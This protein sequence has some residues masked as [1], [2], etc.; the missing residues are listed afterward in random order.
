[1]GSAAVGGTGEMVPVGVVTGD[2][3]DT[4][5]STDVFSERDGTG[6]VPRGVEPCNG[7]NSAMLCLAS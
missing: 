7:L 4:V 3:A 2:G 6:V 5:A 1:M